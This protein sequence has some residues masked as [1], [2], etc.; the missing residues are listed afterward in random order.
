MRFL[1]FYVQNTKLMLAKFSETQEYLVALSICKKLQGQGFLALFAGGCV[2]DALMGQQPRDF[3]IATSAS[4]EQ[5]EQL[6]AKTVGVGRSFGVIVVIQ[7]GLQTEVASFRSDGQYV[8][9][10]HPSSIRLSTPLEDAQRRDFTINALFWDPIKAQLIDYVEGLA[11]LQKKLIR[12]VG[13]PRQRFSEDHLRLL[14]VVRFA[15]Q[16]G[17]AI[18]EETWTQLQAC[19]SDVN[20]VSVERIREE[21]EKLLNRSMDLRGLRVLADSGL[22]AALF[23]GLTGYREPQ[24]FFSET[25]TGIERWL[26]FFHWLAAMQPREN[27]AKEFDLAGTLKRLKFS[28]Q[29]KRCLETAY[30]VLLQ[31]QELE[32]LRPGRLLEKSYDSNWWLG[33]SY[34][35]KRNPR[36]KQV[37]ASALKG[38]QTLG[39]TKPL[40]LVTGNDLP[41][42]LR[43]VEIG[44]ILQECYWLQLEGLFSDRTAALDWIAQESKDD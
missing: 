39:S 6:F 7:E 20:Q 24:F 9:G 16:L 33:L 35:A 40:R 29:E 5:I 1:D 10:R 28:N 17:F 11:D 18:E 26:A 37:L 34:A 21:L 4:P 30:P 43:G 14:R 25:D 38:Q 3:D 23:P 36:L 31:E 12:A 19:A 13:D 22:L 8:D 15:G 2:R 41:S 32:N 44:K 27:G 42:R